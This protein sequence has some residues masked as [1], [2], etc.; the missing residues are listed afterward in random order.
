MIENKYKK[1]AVKLAEEA[2][3]V[4]LKY[5]DNNTETEWKED[6]TPVTIADKE[7]NKLV[8]K[9]IKE[10]FPDHNIIGEEESALNDNSEY[11]WVCDPIDGT[12]PYMH[13]IPTSVFSLA[14]VRDGEVILGVTYDPFMKKLFFAQKGQ[15]A[16]LN[17]KKIYIKGEQGN[18]KVR[19]VVALEW[20]YNAPNKLVKLFEK[21]NTNEYIVAIPISIVYDSMM[22]ASG[23]FCGAIFA[24]KTVHDIAAVKIIVEEAGGIV[25]DLYGND[26]RYDGEIKGAIIASEEYHSK[27][28]AKVKTVINQ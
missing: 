11:S 25:T 9:T 14:L 16:F 8:I 1:I 28:L 17:G 6:K 10:N 26:Q 20:W 5:F 4:M 7:I 22:V 24:G 21:L 19:Q 13:G 18:K 15:G 2:G 23:E 12:I 27:L 3:R